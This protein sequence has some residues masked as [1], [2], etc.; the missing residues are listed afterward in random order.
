MIK[1]QTLVRA[2]SAQ[3]TKI[4]IIDDV[5]DWCTKHKV[6]PIQLVSEDDKKC[7]VMHILYEAPDEKDEYTE[8][9]INHTVKIK[10]TEFG[11]QILK[12]RYNKLKEGYTHMP[13][14]NPLPVDEDGYTKMQLWC[15][16]EKFGNYVGMAREVPFKTKILIKGDL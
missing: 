5:C 7:Y 4:H 16:M 10:I 9:N 14:Y 2:K 15:V 12:D 1:R 6:V 8:F 11:Q 3:Y 13:V